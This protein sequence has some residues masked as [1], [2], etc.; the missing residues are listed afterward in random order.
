MKKQTFIVYIKD[1][2]GNMVTF[3]RFSCKKPETVRKAM[4]KLFENDLYRVCNRAAKK[5][6]LWDTPNGYKTENLIA[7][8]DVELNG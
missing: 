7:V 5:I 4:I 8:W 6:E 1:V 2:S 3:E